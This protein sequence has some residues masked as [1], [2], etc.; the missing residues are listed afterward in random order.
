MRTNGI[1]QAGG[2]LALERS[3]VTNSN[4]GEG[5]VTGI[6]ARRWIDGWWEPVAVLFIF[7]ISIFLIM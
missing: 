6:N 3:I 5:N 4:R 1:Q 7:C 2:R